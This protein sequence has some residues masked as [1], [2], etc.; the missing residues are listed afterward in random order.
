MT[1]KSQT[2]QRLA[3]RRGRWLPGLLSVAAADPLVE[4]S[5]VAGLG[6]ALCLWLLGTAFHPQANEPPAVIRPTGVKAL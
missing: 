6:C 1:A 5:V 4:S 3:E 2:C